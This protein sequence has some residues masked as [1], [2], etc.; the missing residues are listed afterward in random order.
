MRLLTSW[1]LTLVLMLFGMLAACGNAPGSSE[2]EAAIKNRSEEPASRPLTAAEIIAGELAAEGVEPNPNP[3]YLDPRGIAKLEAL[4]EEARQMELAKK[5]K[6]LPLYRDVVLNYFNEN[7][8]GY[9]KTG[10]LYW[11][12]VASC[13]ASYKA[14][15][16][17]VCFQ[18][19]VRPN[20]VYGHYSPISKFARNALLE[21]LESTGRIHMLEKA[22]SESSFIGI[23]SA[24]LSRRFEAGGGKVP[25]ILSILEVT[26]AKV[27]QVSLE[28]P[29]PCFRRVLVNMSVRALNDIGR[30]YL[31]EDGVLSTGIPGRYCI[32]KGSHDP[33]FPEYKIRNLRASGKL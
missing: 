22:D 14:K 21:M 15:E 18:L 13:P 12:E 32:Y 28:A 26:E 3:P 19:S 2:D 25:V 9:G 5:D 31:T 20:K 23:K 30:E 33:A 17:K 1:K 29:F 24:Y 11:G 16:S 27:G 6:L 7:Y 8:V 4:N 10:F